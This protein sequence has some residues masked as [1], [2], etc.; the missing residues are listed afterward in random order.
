MMLHEMFQHAA[1]QGQEEAE[2]TVCQGHRHELPKLDLEAHLSAIQL[3]GPQTS[4]EEIQSL[5]YEVYKCWRLPGSP[6]QDL[7]LEEEVVS[8][9]EDHQGWKW[10]EAPQT[11][12]P[13]STDIQPPR[14]RTPRRGRR[15]AS[16]KR[17][18]AKVKDAHQKALAMAAALEEEIEQLSCPHVRS[19]PE[20]WAHSR[21][22]DCCRCRSKGQRGDTTRCAPR[23]AMPP[24]WEKVLHASWSV[25]AAGQIPPPSR[26]PRPRPCNWG[27]GLVQI[28]WTEGPKVMTTLQEPLT[29]T[30][31]GCHPVSDDASWFSGSDDMPEE[32]PVSGRGLWGTPRPIDRSWQ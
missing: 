32:G 27:E 1:D 29:Y 2:H 11:V 21:S 28:P 22:R 17:S 23:T 10:R 18:L 15:G 9:F 12:K 19:W 26:G 3:V 30:R 4:K 5:Y 25:V 6:S 7:E 14:S 20:V 8:S 24:G 13:K 16:V 31:V